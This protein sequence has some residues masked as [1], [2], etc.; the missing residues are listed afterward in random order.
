M[1]L[2][3]GFLHILSAFQVF[4]KSQFLY[5]IVKKPVSLSY[6]AKNANVLTGIDIPSLKKGLLTYV[7]TF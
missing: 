7:T 6:L 2:F 5:K 4:G 1:S 3:L